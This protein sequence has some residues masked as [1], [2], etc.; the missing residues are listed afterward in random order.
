MPIQP[1]CSYWF[2]RLAGLA[3]FGLLA[4]APNGAGKAL[5]AP[6]AADPNGSW[7][8]THA[9]PAPWGAAIPGSPDLT[10]KT[11]IIEDGKLRGPAPF[12]CDQAQAEA[13]DLPAEGLFQGGLPAP[14]KQAAQVLG[15]SRFPLPSIAIRCS[16]GIFDFHRADNDTLLIALDNRI[17]TL[18]RAPGAVAATNQPEGVAERLLEAHFGAN[19]GFEPKSVENKRSYLSQDL[20]RAMESYF[21]KPQAPDEVPAIDGDPFTDSQET[22]TRFAVGKAEARG[23]SAKVTVIFA[24]AWRT[25]NLVYLLKKDNAGWRLDDI[26]YPAGDTLRGLLQ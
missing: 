23:D 17:W 18:S 16:S 12:E 8:F 3:V 20:L 10:G 9:L 13:V 5:A 2:S 24:D 1:K 11:L 21:A 15:L 26:I 6:P 7:R 19:M 25:V 4:A 14:V 22:P